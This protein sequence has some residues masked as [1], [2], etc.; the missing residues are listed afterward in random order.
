MASKTPLPCQHGFLSPGWQHSQTE[1][2]AAQH[3]PEVLLFSPNAC[4]KVSEI[5]AAAALALTI[6]QFLNSTT[7]KEQ[8]VGLLN[9]MLQKLTPFLSTLLPLLHPF[10]SAV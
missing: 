1:G 7:T 10:V 5:T 2:G 3:G 9:T 4:Q 6:K 8:P